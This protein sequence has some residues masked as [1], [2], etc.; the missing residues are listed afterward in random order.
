MV[1]INH[2]L[3][4]ENALESKEEELVSLSGSIVGVI[5]GVADA[6]LTAKTTLESSFNA[7]E[8]EEQVSFSTHS[9]GSYPRAGIIND[10]D[11]I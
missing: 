3:G 9:R 10:Q 2:K 1:Q 7:K 5:C 6:I 11:R 4:D 8:M